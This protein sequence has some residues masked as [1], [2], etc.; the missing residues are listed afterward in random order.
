MNR[1]L[2]CYMKCLVPSRK[3]TGKEARPINNY[4]LPLWSESPQEP[5]DFNLFAPPGM[6]RLALLDTSAPSFQEPCDNHSNSQQDQ[7]QFRK[8]RPER[9]FEKL[10]FRSGGDTKV[11]VHGKAKLRFNRDCQRP[12]RDRAWSGKG[13]E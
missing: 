13:R 10:S 11:C 3:N 9:V 8:R 1:I 5:E 6:R 2:D 7:K 12:V 4:Q